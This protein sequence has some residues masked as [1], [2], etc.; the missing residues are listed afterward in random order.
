MWI[1]LNVNKLFQCF[2]SWIY[3]TNLIYIKIKTKLEIKDFQLLM[4]IVNITFKS[5]GL[6]KSRKL[7]SYLRLTEIFG[8]FWKKPLHIQFS[9]KLWV[10]LVFVIF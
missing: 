8:V 10:N 2:F 9:L 3:F 6:G 4:L 7:K 5:V 1:L